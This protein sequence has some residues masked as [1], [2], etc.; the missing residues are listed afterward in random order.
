[1]RCKEG[2]VVLH[3]KTEAIGHHVF[4]LFRREECH[5]TQVRSD[6]SLVAPVAVPQKFGLLLSIGSLVFWL[7]VSDRTSPSASES[8]NGE[9]L[10]A[11]A[12]FDPRSLSNHQL[13]L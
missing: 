9:G 5:L 8:L 1:M 4:S 10:T 11:R 13:D 6:I 12:A 7:S 3:K 2:G